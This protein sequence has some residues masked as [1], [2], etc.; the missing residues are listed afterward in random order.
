M[1]YVRERE[2]LALQGPSV[3]TL[4]KF[5]GMHRGHQKLINRVLEIGKKCCETVVCAFETPSRKLLTG[6]ERYALLDAMGID[7]LAD[8]GLLTRFRL[9]GNRK[10]IHLRLT[11]KA[12]PIVEEGREI[13][14]QYG[15]LLF[16]GFSKED[17]RRLFALLNRVAENVDAALAEEER[18]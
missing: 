16:A 12:G 6:E 1:K 3:V 7:T 13:Q 8:R 18:N 11:E 9:E 15:E 4:G 5:N 14:R 2:K 17:R 10:T